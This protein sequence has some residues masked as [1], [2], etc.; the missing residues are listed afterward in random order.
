VNL[1]YNDNVTQNNRVMH[2][3]IDKKG[4][5][6]QKVLFNSDEVYTGFVPQ[7]GKQIGYNRFLVPLTMDKKPLLLKLTQD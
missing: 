5:I 4:A 2:V 6:L 1:L 7:E 3:S